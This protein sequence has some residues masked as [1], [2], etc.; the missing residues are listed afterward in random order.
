V[1]RALQLCRMEDVTPE[2]RALLGRR[3]LIVEGKTGAPPPQQTRTQ[4]ATP[5]NA[6]ALSPVGNVA[7]AGSL[8]SVFGGR[9]AGGT[10]SLRPAA[11][12]NADSR[13]R[14]RGSRFVGK[15]QEESRQLELRAASMNLRVDRVLQ[16]LTLF[17]DRFPIEDA[18]AQAEDGDVVAMLRE[19]DLL[20]AERGN[21]ARGGQASAPRSNPSSPSGSTQAEAAKWKRAKEVAADENVQ[22]REENSRLKVEVSNLREAAGGASASNSAPDRQESSE[23]RLKTLMTTR[24][25][26][27]A[28]LRNAIGVVDALVSEARRELNAAELRKRRAAYERL[29]HAMEKDDEDALEK[30]IEVARGTEVDDGE[31]IKAECKLLELRNLTPDQ[32]AAKAALCL[33]RERKKEAFMLV[34]RD[35]VDSLKALLE[36]LEDTNCNWQE[37][38]D[39]AGRS[40]FKAS[41]QLRAQRVQAYLGPLC[42]Q[43]P[44]ATIARLRRQSS[45][46]D[47]RGLR[48]TISGGSSS[49][50]GARPAE[51]EATATRP[52]T[53]RQRLAEPEADV[54]GVTSRRAP[55]SADA[56][57][58]AALIA[59]ETE[60]LPKRIDTSSASTPSKVVKIVELPTTPTANGSPITPLSG[61]AFNSRLTVHG[62]DDDPHK[63]LKA[64]ALRAVAQ[65]DPDSLEEV[66][67]QVANEVWSKWENR[68]GKDLLTLSQERGSTAAYSMLARTLGLLQEQVRETYEER[69][70]V[71][72]FELGEVQ[73]RRATIMEDTPEEADE[74][75]V[76][77]W[78]GD[79]P[80]A[81]VERCIVRKMG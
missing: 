61:G 65:D 4:P 68:A 49:S 12:V 81:R 38:R 42:G 34:K 71:W 18:G 77:F 28:D 26:D 32:K 72:V 3:L 8:G 35:D 2:L 54:V 55:I 58:A 74:I 25:V 59:Q 45:D 75:L 56:A 1:N 16:R 27:T 14:F 70:T 5:T 31:L 21:L 50:A 76:E 6:R 62:S 51:P 48:A 11:S 46:D 22:L 17:R 23:S 60:E 57:A 9:G 37:W 13:T 36:I 33:E 80:A 30:A 40:L 41:E 10:A 69:E 64:K 78:D 73:P 66:L 7:Q 39:Y 79:A 47:D 20:L 63:E 24:N 29:H 44:Q 19:V 43:K 52:Q 15:E 67:G 53:S